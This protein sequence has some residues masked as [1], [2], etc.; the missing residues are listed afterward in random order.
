MI[1][2]SNRDFAEWSDFFEDPV[3]AAPSHQR[4]SLRRR[5]PDRRIRLPAAINLRR[6]R[7]QINGGRYNWRRLRISGGD[8]AVDLVYFASVFD[9]KSYG[10]SNTR[11]M[12]IPDQVSDAP[13][14]KYRQRM[15]E[16]Y[17]D[18]FLDL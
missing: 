13:G 12:I 3:A 17:H 18:F 4:A 2:T 5:N 9:A 10:P 15:A 6:K 8:R 11:S 7:T 1:L 16:Q 14:M